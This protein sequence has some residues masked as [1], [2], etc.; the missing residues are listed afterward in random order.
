MKY[1]DLYIEIKMKETPY[2]STT[3]GNLVEYS[4]FYVH[5]LC[6]MFYVMST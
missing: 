2:S 5:I 4:M 3:E 6:F 1:A